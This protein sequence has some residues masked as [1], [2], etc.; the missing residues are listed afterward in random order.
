M[1]R[2]RA[3][4]DTPARK[5][6]SEVVSPKNEKRVRRAP[7]KVK[8]MIDIDEALKYEKQQG[9]AGDANDKAASSWYESSKVVQNNTSKGGYKQEK[10]RPPPRF[11]NLAKYAAERK[12]QNAQDSCDENAEAD[13]ENEGPNQAEI[14]AE[15]TLRTIK[16]SEQI[17]TLLKTSQESWLQAQRVADDFIG[18]VA[19]VG[20]EKDTNN[21]RKRFDGIRKRMIKGERLEWPSA[22]RPKRGDTFE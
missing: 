8:G 11:P 7:E 19:Y 20:D 21:A 10:A 6:K 13:E 1:A 15:V 4:Y 9:T 2:S 18:Y 12:T 3:H 17:A 22:K 5:K 14:D 16:M